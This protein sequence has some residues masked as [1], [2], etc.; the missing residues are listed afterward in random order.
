M[1]A[2]SASTPSRPTKQWTLNG[3]HVLYG[4]F[5]F[6]GVMIAV[7]MLFL[8]FALT[9]FTGIETDDA[10]RKGIAYNVRLDEGRKLQQ[11]GWGGKFAFANDRVEV[12]ITDPA[13]EPVRG[14]QLEGR[15]GRPAT[16]KYDTDL[17]FTDVGNGLYAANPKSL[18]SGNWIVTVESRQPLQPGGDIR[19]RL[20]DRL[21]IS[22]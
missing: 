10:Y 5:A 6:F 3:W 2:I 16:D 7:N 13:G 12:R 18:D 11:L 4:L 22:P 20:K 8:Y 9:T 19:F 17:V 21:W 1:T 14:L 15:I